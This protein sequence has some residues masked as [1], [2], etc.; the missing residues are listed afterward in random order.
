MNRRTDNFDGVCATGQKI[1]ANGTH[2]NRNIFNNV[3]S[4][5]DFSEL[6]DRNELNFKNKF[7][8]VRSRCRAILF[9]VLYSPF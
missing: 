1:Y 2:L 3:Y 7:K 6:S 4:N 9:R 8:L 5:S